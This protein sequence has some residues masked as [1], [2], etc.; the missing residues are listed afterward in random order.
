MINLKH[1]IETFLNS[2]WCNTNDKEQNMQ[3]RLYAW[4]LRFEQIGY[5][6]E[7]ETSVR[8]EH[9]KCFKNKVWKDDFSLEK[10][11]KKEMDLFI[12][13]KAFTEVYA[14]E[15]KWI[16]KRDKGWNILDN[17]ED[18]KDDAKFCYQLVEH[19][20]FTETCSVVVQDFERSKQVQ[21]CSWSRNKPGSY[22]R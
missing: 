12:Y 9:L 4:L 5:V 19:G 21:R 11:A 20:G 6:V 3:G 7:M 17:L 13:N 22:S 8:D 1:E 10:F 14:A 2:N 18:F 15:L 16:Y